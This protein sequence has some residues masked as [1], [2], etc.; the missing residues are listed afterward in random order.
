M[1]ENNVLSE[2]TLAFAIRVV[3]GYKYLVDNKKEFVLSKQILRCGTSIGANSNEAIYAQSKADFVSKLSIA[4]KEASETSYWLT[5]LY[6]TSY[7]EESMYVSM[8]KDLDE[9]IRI[10]VKTIKTTRMNECNE[11]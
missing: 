9:I 4:L 10:I 2:K 1:V 8:K 3:N 5:L 11:D 6:R 7:I